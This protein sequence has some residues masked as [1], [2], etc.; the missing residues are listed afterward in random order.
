MRLMRYNGRAVTA[1]FALGLAT[2]LGGCDKMKNSLLDAV[3]PDIIDPSSVQSPAGAVAVRNGA[4]SR[5]RV[6]TAD[7]T[8]TCGSGNESSWIF[9][10]LLADEFASSSTFVQN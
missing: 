4:L 6:A 10:G 5:L 3:D 7:C 9:G 8:G 1:T 2:L